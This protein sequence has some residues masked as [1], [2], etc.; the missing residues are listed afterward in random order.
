MSEK[1]DLSTVSLK[2]S[3]ILSEYMSF[4]YF[5]DKSIA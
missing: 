5:M 1:Q 3:E 2:K 4:V